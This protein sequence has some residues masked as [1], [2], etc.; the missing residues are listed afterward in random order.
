[1]NGVFNPGGLPQEK[2]TKEFGAGKKE[3]FRDVP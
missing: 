1:M 3:R 2:L